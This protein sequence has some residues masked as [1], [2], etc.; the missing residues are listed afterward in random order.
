MRMSGTPE[1]MLD[2]RT[3]MGTALLYGIILM[4]MFLLPTYKSFS[5]PVVIMPAIP[6]VLIGALWG[7]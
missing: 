3:R 7:L 5:V 4:Y 1:D 6:L 2:A